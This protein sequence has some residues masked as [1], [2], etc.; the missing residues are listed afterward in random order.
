V[1]VNVDGDGDGDVLG[2]QPFSASGMDLLERL[3]GDVDETVS[4]R[5]EHVAVAV[6]VHD[7]V[8]DDVAATTLFT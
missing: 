2:R 5:V 6:H 1:D 8:Y 4:V 3:R 7:H